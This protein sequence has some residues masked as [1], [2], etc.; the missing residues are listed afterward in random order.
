M[1]IMSKAV[2]ILTFH[3]IGPFQDKLTIPPSLFEKTLKHIQNNYNIISYNDFCNFIFYNLDLPE[4]SILITLDDGYLDNFIYAFP[5]LKKLHIPAV[6]FVIT[7]M[8]EQASVIRTSMPPFKS[9]KDLENQPDKSYFINSSEINLMEKS[10]IINVESHSVSHL[11]C[12]NQPYEKIVK[13]LNGSYQFI[14]K[15]TMKKKH[16]GFC[17]PK[18]RYDEVA[19]R[20]IKESPYDFSFSTKQ[21]TFCYGDDLFTIP[22]ID[23]S[24]WNGNEKK[25][26]NRIKRKLFIFTNVNISNIYTKFRE[27]RYKMS[28]YNA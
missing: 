6:L 7:G 1:L 26:L 24:S 5:I 8:V 21:G 14:K 2:T 11:T 13:E 16:Y 23:C 15:M 17:W 3:H 10:G 27:I 28:H 4:K 22:R 25:Y 20:A 12:Q 9:H 18:G 19:L